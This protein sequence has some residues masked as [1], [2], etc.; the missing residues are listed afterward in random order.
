MDTN[1][2]KVQ[3]PDV[4][5]WMFAGRLAGKKIK[6]QFFPRGVAVPVWDRK[7]QAL[8][9]RLAYMKQVNEAELIEAT[10]AKPAKGRAAKAPS[11]QVISVPANWRTLHHLKRISLAKQVSNED[12]GTAARADEILAAASPVAPDALVEPETPQPAP[13]AEPEA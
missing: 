12:V 11:A 3:F 7:T 1:A 9:K 8:L 13:E 10:N 4:K 5:Y 2:I 6:G